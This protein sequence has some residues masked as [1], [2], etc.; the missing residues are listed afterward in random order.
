MVLGYLMAGFIFASAADAAAPVKKI[1]ATMFPLY[2]FS[3]HIG[4]DKVS[5]YMLIPP[6]VEIHSFEI[7]P[8]DISLLNQADVLIYGGDVLEPWVKKIISSLDNKK[9]VVIDTSQ[10]IAMV[11]QA[12]HAH[13]HKHHDGCCSEGVDPHYWLDFSLAQKMVTQISDQLGNHDVVNRSYY[14]KNADQCIAQIK[15]LDQHYFDFFNSCKNK[16]IFYAGHFAFG[17][18]AKRYQIQFISPYE[19]FSPNAEPSAKRLMEVIKKI[20]ASKANCIFYEELLE[21]KY[22]KIIA[23]ESKV[24][25][26]LLHGAHNISRQELETKITFIEIMQQNLQ[27]LK[28]CLSCR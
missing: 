15:E 12:D 23:E 9:L 2:D 4:G 25:M 19:G 10:G 1:I 14:Q 28:S 20:K 21:P 11:Q 6:G 27:R 7:K 18:L 17:Y 13:H 22:A 16:T 5:V 8:G 3:R 24:K 26:V